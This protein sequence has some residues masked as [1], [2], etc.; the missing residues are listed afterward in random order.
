MAAQDTTPR[1]ATRRVDR[2]ELMR[3]VTTLSSPAFE[4]RRTGSPGS[5]KARVWLVE[6]FRDARVIP[7]G[8]E[9]FLQ[10]FTLTPRDSATGAASTGPAPPTQSA[11]NVLGRVAGRNTRAQ[12]IVVMAHFDH[13]GVRNGT[14]Y[15][16]ADDNASGVAV[17]LAAARHFALEAPR[18]PMLFAALDAEEVGFRGARALVN[19]RLLPRESVG[20]AVNLD[21][22]SRNDRNEIFAA[23][24]YHTPWL[25][26]L[27]RDVQMRS[28]VTIRLGHDRPAALSEGL[29]DWTRSSDHGPFHEAGI[30]FVYFGA[31]DHGDYHKPTDTADRIDPRFFG[32]AA[33]MIVEALRTLDRRVD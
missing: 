29:E 22:V 7:A 27:V 3:D 5:L 31:E 6:E 11:A 14:V 26:P 2:S 23:G 9:D 10:P 30:P 20:V 21:M 1:T 12:S 33:D 24:T 28:A 17:L 19:S 8:T 4:G 13:L 16:G 32:D 25:A 15:P 18:H